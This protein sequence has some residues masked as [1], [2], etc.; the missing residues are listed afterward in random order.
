VL[1]RR[2]RPSPF[3]VWVY[4]LNRE[5]VNRRGKLLREEPI[6]SMLKQKIYLGQVPNAKELEFE[7]LN[8]SPLFD[9]N[10]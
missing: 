8:P 6:L 4:F 9:F 5:L 2:L 3:W 1:G 7:P 10:I